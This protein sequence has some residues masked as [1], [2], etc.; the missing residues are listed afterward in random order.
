MSDT[1]KQSP[2]GANSASSLLQNTGLNINP[3]AQLHM[4]ISKINSDYAPGLTVNNTCLFWLTY[5]INY[6][7]LSGVLTDAIYDDLISIGY[8]TIP[9]LGNARPNTYTDYD[10][11]GEWS[12]QATTGYGYAG[13]TDQGQ[14]AT[15]YPYDTT[16]PNVSVTQWGFIR[17][18]ALQAW[19]EFNYNGIPNG[20]GMPVYKDFCSSFMICSGFANYVNVMINSFYYGPEYLKGVYSNMNDLITAEAT[21]ISLTPRIFGQD[22]ITLGKAIDLSRINSFG[23]PSSLLQTINQYNAFSQSLSLALLA[24]GIES[25]VVESIANGTINPTTQQEQQI[26]GAFTIIVG[27]D[28]QDILIPLNC[29]TQGLTSLA[30]LLNVSKIF[31]NSYQTI[32]V[33]I[34]NEEQSVNNSK[35]YYPIYVGTGL[36]N[37]LTSPAI[38]ELIGTIILPGDPNVGSETFDE[39]Q[40]LPKGFDSY[41][42]NILPTSVAVAA[43]AFSYTMRQIKNIQYVDFESFSQVVSN[44]ETRANLN[45]INGTDVP[46]D[47]PL[48]DTGHLIIALGSGPN[49]TYTTSDFFGCMSGL[50]YNWNNLTGLIQNTETLKLKNIYIELYLAITWGQGTMSLTIVEPSPGVYQV[51]SITISNAGGGYGRG[52]AVAP[53]IA[54][55]NGASATCTIGTDPTNLS[56]FGKIISV[57]LTGP[58][59]SGSGS[60]WTV[61]V[62]APPTATLPVQSNGNR[63]TGGTNTA[64]GTVGYPAPMQSVVSAYIT[65]AETEIQTIFTTNTPNVQ[66]LVSLYEQF[67]EQLLR[68]Q[69]ARYIGLPEVPIPRDTKLN[70]FPVTTLTF[71]DNLYEFAQNT[72]PHMEAQTVEAISNLNII[73]GQSIVGV[74][75]E[76]RN[77]ARL[78][79]VGIPLDNTMPGSLDPES[80]LELLSNGVTDYEIADV[81]FTTIPSTEVQ[82]ID[83]VSV[84]PD[85]IG[86]LIT[87]DSP[88]MP[89]ITIEIAPG[90]APIIGNVF[91]VVS[92]TP[93]TPIYIIDG[94][95][96][97]IGDTNIIGS[98]AGSPVTDLIP[99]NLNNTLT[100][101]NKLPSDY[102]V[103]EA[104]EE[105]I[106]CNCTCWMM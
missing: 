51:G 60:G 70:S 86:E 37:N 40:E 65:Q 26:Y 84:T 104:I 85:Q 91:P 62:Q 94:N 98:F 47:V 56:T 87:P 12:G 88:E 19:N 63:N 14:D 23:L 79:T 93:E 3:N 81:T 25:L 52:L 57:I 30:D 48:M 6:A 4:G 59:S 28:L 36:N 80:L 97:D 90:G 46:P 66:E 21:N 82:I 78:Q 8:T 89:N 95:P 7:Y 17:C 29:K 32:T 72:L 34:Y 83:G 100:S 15:W 99:I 54:I 42:I 38:K 41:L 50:P 69:R 18:F 22:C 77:Q 71:V 105:V 27:Q 103:Q 31:P 2:L 76:S 1:A 61:S 24:S 49:R 58:G 9:A 39:I 106:H 43:G 5:A 44:I 96:I 10:P 102:T 92:I 64:S 45:L 11:S 20:A 74:L 55:S 33:P 68:E 13:N 16:N 101:G 67:G 75:R 53:T 35:T 73:G